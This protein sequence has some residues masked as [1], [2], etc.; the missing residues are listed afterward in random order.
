MTNAPI[1][2]DNLIFQPQIQSFLVL[3]QTRSF[4]EAGRRLNICQSAVSRNISTLEK[5]LGIELTLRNVRP[6]HITPEGRSF[7]ETVTRQAEQ[8]DNW[9]LSL[10]KSSKKK[11]SLRLGCVGSISSH[12]NAEIIRKTAS[13]VSEYT[14]TEGISSALMKDFQ[15]SKLDFIISSRPFF[16][17]DNI[18]RKY[19]LSEPSIL[20]VP[21]SLELPKDATWINLTF[22]GLP[23]ICNCETSS[24]GQ[25]EVEFFHEHELSFVDKIFVNRFEPFFNFIANGFGWGI[26]T[27]SAV[28]QFPKFMDRI[29]VLPL[30]DPS[31][32]RD[33]YMISRKGSNYEEMAD[34]LIKITIEAFSSAAENTFLKIAPWATNSF[35]I[36]NGKTNSR[37][38]LFS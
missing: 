24:F 9:L 17:F 28:S 33:L 3:C 38:K 4:S 10:H 7:Y 35:F 36:S 6:I 1:S 8:F 19:L 26:T 12:V 15:E 23:R 31:L 29:K 18:Y 20:V 13:K 16:Q 22:C 2:I 34:E 14:L 5:K 30:E 27:L 11:I 37:R 21:K 32:S 25:L